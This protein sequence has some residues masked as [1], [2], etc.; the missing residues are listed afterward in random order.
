LTVESTAWD[1]SE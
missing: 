1:D